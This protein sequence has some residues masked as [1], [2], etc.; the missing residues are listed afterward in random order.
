[1]PLDLVAISYGF[2]HE[3]LMLSTT[4]SGAPP[5]SPSSPSDRE[6]ID[7]AAKEKAEQRI[8]VLAMGCAEFWREHQDLF[9]TFMQDRFCPAIDDYED[10]WADPD[11][12]RAGAEILV[13]VAEHDEAAKHVALDLTREDALDR[14]YEELEAHLATVF[15]VALACAETW[16]KTPAFFPTF[17]AKFCQVIDAHE[18][19]QA[20][21]DALDDGD[22]APAK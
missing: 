2:G 15:A 20:R 19:I 7:R 6:A 5:R 13:K 21:I 12:V 18:A 10:N 9:L 14:A 1:M 8:F 4:R 3:V 22:Q 17:M 11:A 16:R